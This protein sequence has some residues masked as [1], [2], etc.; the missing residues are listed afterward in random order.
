MHQN[1]LLSPLF[2]PFISGLCLCLWAGRSLR[3]AEPP[4]A[5][6]PVEELRQALETSPDDIKTLRAL[7]EKRT[8][9][10][11][12]IPDLYG[13]L[14]LD[15]WL[16]GDGLSTDQADQLRWEIRT[17]VAKRYEKAI[18]AALKEDNQDVQLAAVHFLGEAGLRWAAS[19]D[20]VGLNRVFT[21]D[22]VR[23]VNEGKPEI[24][25]AAARALGQ[26]NPP[27]DKAVP[28]LASLLEAKEVA[29]R[30]AAAAGF[31]NLVNSITTLASGKGM[32]DGAAIHWEGARACA[33]VI[34]KA[35]AGLGDTDA[36]V[37]RESVEALRQAAVFLEEWYNP[38]DSPFRP[39][40]FRY[41]E[42]PD[43]DKSLQEARKDLEALAPLIHA[44]SDQVPAVTRVLT[45][46]DTK[47]CLAANQTLEALA[48]ARLRLRAQVAGI[49]RLSKGKA[50]AKS[51][52][53]YLPQGLTK[54]LPTLAKELTHENVRVRLASL[55]VLETLGP[56]A[57]PV[58]G[59]VASALRDKDSFV[60]WGAARA[61]GKMAPLEP[62][63]TVP[64]LAKALEDENGD[65]RATAALERYG[66]AAKAAAPALAR[67]VS[68]KE[69]ALSI[70]AIR[71][72]AAVG[73]AAKAEAVPVLVKA[74]SS[75]DADLR[76]A[77]AQ[78]LA[79]FPPHTGETAAALRKALNDA[80]AQVRQ[81]A[82]AA[83][84]AK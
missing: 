18:R 67:A 77:A 40:R 62:T 21:P 44:L 46:A 75:P 24:Q 61:L 38:D 65:V 2:V 80:E 17:Q 53:D 83:L 32:R 49:V 47:G 23:L 36:E 7:L 19:R 55:Y 51:P 48:G 33:A 79:K 72:L 60:R 54:A 73:P 39:D 68:A 28:S 1:R 59:A 6:S 84:L 74:L 82:S 29:P 37:R 81:A 63:K 30:R 4:A 25:T 52:E 41:G 20:H 70:L 57:A 27:V 16:R 64:A 71:A 66:P 34:P 69:S 13:A 56:E 43:I 8:A 42:K 11:K 12:T 76:Y 10:L 3:A 9:A 78:A 58:A 15:D 45:D 31:R 35:A 5:V 14:D 50:L 22:L 26:I